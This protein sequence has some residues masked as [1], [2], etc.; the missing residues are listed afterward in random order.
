MPPRK[1]TRPSKPA[2]AAQEGR[3]RPV[4]PST[5]SSEDSLLVDAPARKSGPL[6]GILLVLWHGAGGDVTER[7]LLAVS[8]AATAAG[9]LVVRARFPYRVAGKR[10]PDRMPVLLASARESIET[11]RGLP[12]AVGRKLALGGRSM[13]GRVASLLVADGFD[14][15]A[16]VFLSYPLHPA[17]KPE[18][19]RD[20]HLDSIQ[21]PM[22]FVQGDRDTLCD[23]DLLRPVLRRLGKR[24]ELVVFP[25]ADHGMRKAPPEEI[26]RAVVTFLERRVASA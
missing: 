21:S 18:Q 9:A 26:A 2:Q 11:A 13:G 5:S 12:G 14:A 23:L 10:A 6:S 16:L 1:P 7:S 25:G 15:A 3:A 19:L 17:G 8:G 4:R 22:L 20:A 24:A